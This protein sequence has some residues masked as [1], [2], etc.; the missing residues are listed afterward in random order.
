MMTVL[1]GYSIGNLSSEENSRGTADRSVG[2]LGH[3]IISSR[4]GRDNWKTS[5]R[6]R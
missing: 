2:R 4:I 5:F 6:N 1:E 3:S